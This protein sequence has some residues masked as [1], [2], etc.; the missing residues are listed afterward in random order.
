M[1]VG[2]VESAMVVVIMGHF[3]YLF[4]QWIWNT[5]LILVIFFIYIVD[6]IVD[7]VEFDT[8]EFVTIQVIFEQIEHFSPVVVLFIFHF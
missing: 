3:E 4:L 5:E 2:T 8:R 7:S 1:D 6:K